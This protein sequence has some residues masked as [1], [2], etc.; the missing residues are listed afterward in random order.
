MLG[1]QLGSTS[2]SKLCL[3]TS[4]AVCCVEPLDRQHLYLT[5]SWVACCSAYCDG[6]YVVFN[7][8]MG[9]MLSWA[10]SWVARCSAYCAWP[11]VGSKL[12]LAVS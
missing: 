8:M 3:V 2:H 7:R 1:G 4:W 10:I 11:P 12:C 5:I 9:S 6:H